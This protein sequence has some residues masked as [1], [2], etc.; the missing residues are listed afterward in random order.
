MLAIDEQVQTMNI[1]EKRVVVEP[2]EILEDILL[3]EN[4]HKRYTRVGVD[5][6]KKMN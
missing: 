6:E 2:T 5:M 3:D 1:K 4:N